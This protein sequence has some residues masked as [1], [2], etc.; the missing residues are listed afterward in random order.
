VN[1]AYTPV[2]WTPDQAQFNISGQFDSSPLDGTRTVEV[3]GNGLNLPVFKTITFDITDLA[4]QW[5]DDPMTNNGV[6]YSD[7]T[8]GNP[9]FAR[10]TF[11]LTLEL[12]VQ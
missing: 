10:E 3:N 12:E 6:L 7:D 4:Q 11:T 5:L 2:Y 8:Q 1:A 9:R